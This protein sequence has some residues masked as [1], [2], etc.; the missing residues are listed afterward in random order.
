[1][2]LLDL[3]FFLWFCVCVFCLFF[4]MSIFNINHNLD[5]W[6]NVHFGEIHMLCNLNS[7]FRMLY[8]GVV[9]RAVFLMFTYSCL[10]TETGFKVKAYFLCC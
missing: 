6:A 7:S 10:L 2:T 3:D 8:S 9:A 1:M 4:F 5:F